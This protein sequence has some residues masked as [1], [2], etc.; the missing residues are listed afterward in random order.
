MMISHVYTNDQTFRRIL[1]ALTEKELR[2]LA[3][4]EVLIMTIIVTLS[5]NTQ[6]IS[7]YLFQEQEDYDQLKDMDEE[8]ISVK[9]AT[10][11]F[12]MDIEEIQSIYDQFVPLNEVVDDLMFTITDER[13]EI[14]AAL[15]NWKVE[16]VRFAD[17]IVMN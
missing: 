1:E 7:K 12:R 16:D 11:L 3:R 5:S 6:E 4:K 13:W 8:S 10:R 9:I 2:N 17:L 14:I 15:W